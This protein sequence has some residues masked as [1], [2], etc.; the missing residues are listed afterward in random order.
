MHETPFEDFISRARTYRYHLL[1]YI[2]A[3]N[4]KKPSYEDEESSIGDRPIPKNST[5]E[6]LEALVAILNFIDIWLK[7]LDQ[8]YDVRRKAYNTAMK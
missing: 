7:L 2:V 8:N 4:L 5:T 1:W 3:H 6:A